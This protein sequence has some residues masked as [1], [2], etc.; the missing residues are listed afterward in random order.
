MSVADSQNSLRSALAA[1]IRAAR[2]KNGMSQEQL[3]FSSDL[4]RTYISQIERG[5][6]SPTIDCLARIASSLRTT[7]SILL[8]LAENP[9]A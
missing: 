7:P 2:L 3:A 6:K 1:Q 8:N 5:Q 4:H 9:V